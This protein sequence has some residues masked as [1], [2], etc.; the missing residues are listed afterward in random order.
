[1]A[2]NEM[3]KQDELVIATV[4]KIM[5]YGAFCALDEYGAREAFIHVSEVA[6][7][8]VKNIHEFLRTGQRVVA[9]VH[10]F[11]P[12]K[13]QIDLS[14]KR[15][16]ES[17]KKSKL[18]GARRLKRGEM[19]MKLAAKK[20]KKTEAEAV[21]VGS[22]LAKKFGDPYGALE[23][24]LESGPQV[25]DGLEIPVEWKKILEEMAAENIKKK[26]VK[27]N[28][29]ITAACSKGNGFEIIK[30]AL[31]KAKAKDWKADVKFSY[32]GA[33]RYMLSVVSPEY[34]D[35]LKLLD[36]IGTEIC[37]EINKH[38]GEASFKAGKED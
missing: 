8:W 31:L 3:P 20:L 16:T 21:K 37:G 38:G 23:E 22:E 26:A 7:R 9:R 29:V 10:K 34:R 35:G 2:A 30:E 6:P 18:E 28:G 14:L 15:V 4:K 19:L 12:E 36:K 25:L 1:M 5:P 24:M 11:I 17:D 27:V 33:P 32:L 13:N